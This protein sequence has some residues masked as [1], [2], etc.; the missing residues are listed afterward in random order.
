M[1]C[2]PPNGKNAYITE[3]ASPIPHRGYMFE[4]CKSRENICVGNEIFIFVEKNKK[5]LQKNLHSK[6]K[7]IT[8]APM[9]PCLILLNRRASPDGAFFVYFSI[10]FFIF[11]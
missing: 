5:Y 11:L 10:I 6:N 8:F 7:D 1:L 3:I 2:T 9:L 4:Q